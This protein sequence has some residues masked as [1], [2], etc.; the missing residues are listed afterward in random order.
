MRTAAAASLLGLCSCTSLTMAEPQ[1]HVSPYLAVYELRGKVA[2]QSETSP[3]GPIEDNE[4]QAMR[5]FG[6][7]HHREDVGVRVDI[8]DGFAGFRVDYYRLDM[9]TADDG[10]L[11]DDWGRLPAGDT[12][13]ASAVM[14]ELRVGYLE[15]L[16]SF[17]TE[18]RD[19][20][21]K[22]AVAGGAVLAHRDLS[23]RARSGGGAS[24]RIDIDGYVAYP[25]LRARLGWREVALDVEYALAPGD[26]VLGGDFD[27]LQQDFE[28][29]LAYTLPMRDVTFFGGY[30][31]SELPAVGTANGFRYDSDL[32]IAGFQFGVVL[33]F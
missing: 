26:F 6:Q 7:D 10:V 32:R 25:A 15:R 11:T 14:D 31:Y 2:L 13:A 12:V 5:T 30:R 18:Y 24:Q 33:T 1:I 22:F 9:G 28:A 3:G 4:P 8:G 17:E 21:L 19:Q 27:D 23:L 29:R 16:F 20:P